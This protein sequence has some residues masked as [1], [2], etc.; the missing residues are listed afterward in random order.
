M[1]ETQIDRL[2]SDLFK[3]DTFIGSL[4]EEGNEDL[5]KKVGVKREY[6]NR[7]INEISMA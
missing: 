3:I 1:V 6:L 2:R 5:A 4:R 7:Y